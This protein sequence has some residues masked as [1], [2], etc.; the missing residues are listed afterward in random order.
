MI[1]EVNFEGVFMNFKKRI[2]ILFALFFLFFNH[3]SLGAEPNVASTSA[4]L[5]ET[6]TGKILY[7]KNA[8]D[9]MYP[10]STTKVM[11]AIL[12]LENCSLDEIATVSHNAVHSIPSGYVNANLQEG[13][14]LSVNDL[15]YALMVKSANDAAVVLAEHI[16]GSVE[17]F[18]N[19]M[20]EKAKEIGCQNTHFV[21]PNGIHHENHY[22]TAYDLYLMANY[23]MQNETFRHFVSTTS[24]ILPITNKYPAQDRVCVT[25]NDML[26]PVSKYYNKNVI[27]IKTG[28]TTEAKNCLIA[29]TRQ[30]S[31][32]LISVVLHAGTNSD[33]LSERY[34]DT[35]AL[36]DYGINDF[37]FSDIVKENDVIV[38]IEVEN[39]TKDTKNLELI[40][41]NTISTYLSKDIDLENLS[42]EINL[43]E[44]IEAPIQAG[45]SL[46]SMTYHIGQEDYSVELLAKT[47]VEEKINFI[48]F[49]ILGGAILLLIVGIVMLKSQR[50]QTKKKKKHRR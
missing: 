49:L 21:N 1:I 32:E 11:T 6:S 23:G 44:N 27:G 10:A 33:G 42:P 39:G 35:A 16:S 12:T 36:F 28:Y 9:K 18:A 2:F 26:R 30:N 47:D 5:V 38:N 37:S 8:Y 43:N 19:K 29:A 22:S 24:Y 25:T 7:E 20:N 46:G 13:E 3:V 40:A 34:I 4:I 14:Q 15:M 45:S 17:D 41:K 48:H 31:I 50:S